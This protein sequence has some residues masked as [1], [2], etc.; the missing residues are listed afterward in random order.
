VHCTNALCCGRQVP[1]S[2][3][4]RL[5][6]LHVP[7]PLLSPSPSPPFSCFGSAYLSTAHKPLNPASGVPGFRSPRVPGSRLFLRHRVNPWCVC[8]IRTD[9]DNTLMGATAR[10][11]QIPGPESSSRMEN[12]VRRMENIEWSGPQFRPASNDDNDN[13]NDCDAKFPCL[14]PGV[15]FVGAGAS[16]IL[17]C[18]HCGCLA[19]KGWPRLLSLLEAF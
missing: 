14:C 5:S 17:R 19:P 18:C 3:P 9:S 2:Q 11:S 7:I 15:A 12:I 1:Q 8:D 10:P 6:T 4:L 13:D 16:V